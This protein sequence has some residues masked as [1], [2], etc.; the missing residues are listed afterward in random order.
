[1]VYH[2]WIRRYASKPF[3]FVPA[4]TLAIAS[5][6]VLSIRTSYNSFENSARDQG[7][8]AVPS[9]PSPPR[10]PF[11]RSRYRLAPPPIRGRPVLPSGAPPRCSGIFR[12]IIDRHVPPVFRRRRRACPFDR[13]QRS[14]STSSQTALA[15]SLSLPRHAIPSRPYIAS[16]KLDFRFQDSHPSQRR[17]F[18][19]Q[20][21]I[22]QICCLNGQVFNSRAHLN[23]TGSG[24]PIPLLVSLI[25]QGSLGRCQLTQ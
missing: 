2:R 15:L 6:S 25:K 12:S 20:D 19:P 7:E 1:M 13:S 24:I 21:F 5:P 23:Q 11:H 22:M 18:D 14:L 17:R 16:Q 3:P 8:M 4:F 9:C 10:I